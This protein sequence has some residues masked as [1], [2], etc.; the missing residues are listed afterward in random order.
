[1]GEN[2]ARGFQTTLSHGTAT[3]SHLH[4]ELSRKSRATQGHSRSSYGV[5]VA[6]TVSM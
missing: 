5:Y 3:G 1:M 6:V 2:L 4:A